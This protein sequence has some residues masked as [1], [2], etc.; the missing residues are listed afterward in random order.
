M[1]VVVR[2]Q[3][4]WRSARGRDRGRGLQ[5]VHGLMDTVEV[6]RSD[7]GTEVRMSRTLA[8]S[9]ATSHAE[10]PVQEQVRV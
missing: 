7:S 9:A 10:I 6:L 5:L 4:Q 2:D 3:G 1:T 8:G